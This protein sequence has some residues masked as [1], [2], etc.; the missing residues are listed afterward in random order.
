MP[1]LYI[2][3]FT[4]KLE[5]EEIMILW[6]VYEI[7]DTE[8]KYH[9]LVGYVPD[10]QTGR[11]TSAIQHFDKDSMRLKT[12]SGRIYKLDGQPALKGEMQPVWD[13]WKEQYNIENDV[14]VTHQYLTKH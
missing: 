6:S 14:D 11:V 4:R 8:N 13:Q 9:H 1:I 2:S 10:R 7:T 3:S 5:P 12:S